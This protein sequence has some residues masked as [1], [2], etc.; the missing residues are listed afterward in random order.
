LVELSQRNAARRQ[1]H[2]TGIDARHPQNR[3]EY[4]SAR[5]QFDNKAKHAWLLAHD[6]DA[7]HH[8]ANSAE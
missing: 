6:A 3:H 7:D 5:E 1:R 4:S 2:S 8:I